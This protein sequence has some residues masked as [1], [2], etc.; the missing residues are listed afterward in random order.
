MLIIQKMIMMLMILITLIILMQQIVLSLSL[1]PSAR[2][3]AADL[4][5]EDYA[6]SIIV[7]TNS[8]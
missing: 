3:D 7:I 8:Y 5:A 4:G 2:K 1:S 6:L